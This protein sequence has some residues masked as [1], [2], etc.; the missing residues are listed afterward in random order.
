MEVGT[1]AAALA[2]T[3]LAAPSPRPSPDT[4]EALRSGTFGSVTLYAPSRPPEQVVLFVSGDGGWNLGV[5]DMARRLA[6]LG[7]LVA[8]IDI[9]AYRGRLAK[10]S[11]CAYPAGDL[12]QLARDVQL[13]RKMPV[14]H[15]PILVG[16]SSGAT[17]VYLALAS[18]PPETFAGGI[19]L[20]F[21]P[22]LA[23]G[24]PP[25]RGARL[26]WTEAKKHGT[27]VFEPAAGLVPSWMVLQGDRDQ[28]CSPEAT[29]RFV[30]EIRSA[31]VFSLP[32]V[33]HGF[34][35]TNRWDAAFVEAYRAV[36]EHP[37]EPPP[38]TMADAS[39]LGVVEVQAQGLE[40]DLL[41]VIL[42]GDGGWAEF[43][44]GVAESLARQGVPAVGWSSLRYYWTPRTPESA[45]A[46]L[47][48]VL[49]HYLGAWR[50]S[51]A[52]L[53][54][55]S[56]GADVLPFLASRLPAE[57]GSRLAGVVLVGPSQ[58]ASFAFHLSS[59]LGGGGDPAFPVH[60][61]LR[62]LTGLAVT[63]VREDDDNESPCA[64]DPSAPVHVVALPGGH[65]FGGDYARLGRIALETASPAR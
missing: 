63:C 39:D 31:R 24:T 36:S 40:R 56:F 51:R 16:Y 30:S 29:R 60:R 22:D 9:G 59:W 5:V 18:A 15:R 34:A 44:K 7:A 21:C 58:R 6:S 38:A 62:R 10:V 32:K 48:R 1:I 43:D 35:A 50:K 28:V 25:C 33:G 55:Y 53:V 61:E 45:A 57:T 17:L 23:L 19:S 47:D 2:M 12:E 49:R 14:Y 46:D 3:L 42:T 37:P 41:A 20:G 26:P 54:G 27:Y 64:A 13:R 65:H 8:G 4:E 11:S 52:L